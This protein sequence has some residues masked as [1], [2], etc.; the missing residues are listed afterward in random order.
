MGLGIT[1][2]C[3]KEITRI[4]MPTFNPTPEKAIS[5]LL[6]SRERPELLF[7]SLQSL[8]EKSDDPKDVEYVIAIDE[9]DKQTIDYAQETI[10]PWFEQEDID[11]TVLITPRYG[12]GQLNEYVN[13]CAVHS[14]G[15]WLIFWNDDAVMI[16]QG[17]DTEVKSHTGQFKVLAFKDNHNDHPY[18]IFPII[19]RDWVMLFETV[20]PQQQ[21]DAWIS[22]VAY[23]S[24]SWERLTSEVIHDRADLT[25][26]NN[27]NVYQT[28][29]YHEGNPENPLDLNNPKFHALKQHYAA[30]VSWLR[31]M[32]GQDTGWWD[33]IVAGA[34]DPW[35]KMLEND[36]NNQMK[37][38]EVKPA[39]EQT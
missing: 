20:S 34:V 17:W 38:S 9:D 23:L 12:Y 21:S 28:R 15:A 27:D 6:P 24:D 39:D 14:K 36:K 13:L 2:R 1:T 19:P 18:A 33:K 5:I 26:N 32:L 29:V 10:L 30:K 7:K 22:Q 3:N 37:I 16:S 25:G 8:I 11:I 35:E 4:K 31:K